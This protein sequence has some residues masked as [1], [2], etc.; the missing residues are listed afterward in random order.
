MLEQLIELAKIGGP[1]LAAVFCILWWLER[2]ERKDAQA[3]NKQLT[4]DTLTTM[5]EM[6]ALLHQ[7][8]T[9]FKPNGGPK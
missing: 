2:D 7:V 3:E 5:A 6:K 1:P 9:I 8:V 4:K